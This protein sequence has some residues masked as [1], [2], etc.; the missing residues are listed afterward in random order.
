MTMIKRTLV[1]PLA[2]AF[3]PFA[4][5]GCSDGAEL[6]KL[7]AKLAEIKARPRGRIEPPPEFNPIATFSYA[8]H[9]L[10]SPFNKPVDEEPI[11]VPE[12]K[13]VE[14]DF[15]RP[16]DYLE[17]F[18]LDSLRMVGTITKPGQELEALIRDPSDSVHRVK[19]G[20]YLGKNFG[21]VVEVDEAKIAVIEIVPDGH[22]GW[23]E[24]P[25]TIRIAD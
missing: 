15:T 24:R 22:D 20:S 2:M 17:R 10:R 18:T 7:D 16:K 19:V 8:A 13:Q 21:R 11:E 5:T 23:V 4:I 1:L 14:P 25:R 12:G 6:N 9:Q 3:I